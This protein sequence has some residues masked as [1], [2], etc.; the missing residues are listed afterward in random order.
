MGNNF[1]ELE[2]F[3]A[4]ADLYIDEGID[5]ALPAAVA[6]GARAVAR[7]L[8]LG[9]VARMSLPA[10]RALVRTIA[11]SARRLI[12]GRG[13][14]AVRALPR[15]GQAV[16]RAARRR[17]LPPAQAA[18]AV[19][20]TLPRT[21][22]AVARSPRLARRLAAPAAGPRPLAR[23][24]GI[25]RGMPGPGPRAHRFTFTGPVTLTIDRR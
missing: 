12:L 11:T 14:Q 18:Q 1:D 25:G 10:R 20:R 24:S 6:L 16:T 19:R 3:D 22:R 4:A 8:G 23:P 21:A 5:E 15:M 17:R 2:A 13:P 9:N 7:G